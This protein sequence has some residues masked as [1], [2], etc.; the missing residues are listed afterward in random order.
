MT[1][2]PF[3][4]ETRAAAPSAATPER[5]ARERGS[6]LADVHDPTASSL[7]PRAAT[8]P[9]R[10][11][12]GQRLPR[13]VGQNARPHRAI[14]TV[15][16]RIAS[17]LSE[18]ARQY[19]VHRANTLAG[20]PGRPR[21]ESASQGNVARARG[22]LAASAALDFEHLVHPARSAPR[23]GVG[24]HPTPER[25]RGKSS[26]AAAR[27]RRPGRS[28]HGHRARQAPTPATL[29]AV[30]VVLFAVALLAALGFNVGIGSSAPTRPPSVDGGAG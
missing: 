27:L 17:S 14:A 28:S 18:W 20:P 9:D 6:R 11:A 26:L 15:F 30:L 25:V 22:H 29:A 16:G 24:E 10:S 8:P 7:D 21:A 2:V 3:P 19:L 4:A 5:D 23:Q 1:H 12:I 13:P